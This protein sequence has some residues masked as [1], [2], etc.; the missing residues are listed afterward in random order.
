MAKLDMNGPYQ[1]NEK[2][3][4]KVLASTRIGNYAL[5]HMNGD[6]FIVNYVGRSDSDVQGR[7]VSWVDES[8]RPLF[9]YSYADTVR[10]AFEKECK[11]YHDFSPSDNEIHPDKPEGKTYPCP[12]CGA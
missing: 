3:I 9:K 2:E 10:E 12:V 6:K 4:K 7:L 1:L 11:N 5:G 8:P